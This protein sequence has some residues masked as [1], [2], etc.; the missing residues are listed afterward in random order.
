MIKGY[1]DSPIGR[2]EIIEDNGKIVS[3]CK[4]NDDKAVGQLSELIQSCVEQLEQYFDKTR[5]SFD[6]PL[7]MRGTEFQKKVWQELLNIPYGKTISYA[8][9][10]DKIGNKNACR[11]VGG[12]NHK[13][14]LMILVPCHRVIGK[15]GDLVGFG[16][17][18]EMK[19]Q[20]LMLD[21]SVE[22]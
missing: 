3:L 7:E 13:N 18:L 9:L 8:D 4:F 11:A 1:Y 6:L 5:T 21:G 17:G 22:S 19:R 16:G 2:L 10:A 15:N 12:A 20:L 14:P